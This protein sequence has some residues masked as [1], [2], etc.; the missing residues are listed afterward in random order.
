MNSRF[1]GVATDVCGI[2]VTDIVVFNAFNACSDASSQKYR[3]S[4][5]SVY[6]NHLFRTVTMFCR[7]EAAADLV[8]SA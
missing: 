7:K 5:V 4:A 8:A 6:K 3:R 2:G 1:T